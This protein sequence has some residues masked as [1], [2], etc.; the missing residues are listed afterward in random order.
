MGPLPTI[1]KPSG[2]PPSRAS[3][4]SSLAGHDGSTLAVG[5]ANSDTRAASS[6]RKRPASAMD[7]HLVVR[8]NQASK[9]NSP[10]RSRGA[11]QALSTLNPHVLDAASPGHAVSSHVGA[12]HMESNIGLGHMGPSLTPADEVAPAEQ[13][14]APASA[15][16]GAQ[17]QGGT[18]HEAI[19]LLVE[20]HAAQQAPAGPTADQQAAAQ[21]LSTFDVDV[22]ELVRE[23]DTLA[24][25][26][27]ADQQAAAQQEAALLLS[28]IDSDAQLAAVQLAA[29]QA[30]Q[31]MDTGLQDTD[32]DVQEQEVQ[33]GTQPSRPLP[34]SPQ[35][36]E[37]VQAKINTA[38]TRL[39]QQRQNTSLATITRSIQAALAALTAQERQDLSA[40]GIELDGRTLTPVLAQGCKRAD[41]AFVGLDKQDISPFDRALLVAVIIRAQLCS[42]PQLNPQSEHVLRT[43]GDTNA[44]YV[45]PRNVQRL[46]QA[47]VIKPNTTYPKRLASITSGQLSHLAALA[48]AEHCGLNEAQ[49]QRLHALTRHHTTQNLQMRLYQL[50]QR[51]GPQV[52]AL[53]HKLWDPGWVATQ[54]SSTNAAT[55]KEKSVNTLPTDHRHAFI[56]GLMRVPEHDAHGVTFMQQLIAAAGNDAALQQL[57]EKIATTV[58]PNLAVPADLKNSLRRLQGLPC[59]SKRLNAPAEFGRGYTEAAPANTARSWLQSLAQ[60][61]RAGQ[62]SQ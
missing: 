13:Q 26:A 16:T 11:L 10:Q 59:V 48:A 15:S 43:S 25:A 40:Q 6:G 24:T 55:G 58:P 21:W 41:Q 54:T 34:P 14:A 19:E 47:A 7:A 9:T 18:V 20:E 3:S 12:G 5:Q 30:H 45:H 60:R 37:R 32:F 51:H 4:S 46:G 61:Q 27:Q 38:S 31:A 2:Q 42:V 62:S 28:A 57:C 8:P 33:H 29:G 53:V 22:Q 39:D 1:H 36:L 44:Q 56:Q 50:S 52:I 23:Y 17:A 49:Y 35:L